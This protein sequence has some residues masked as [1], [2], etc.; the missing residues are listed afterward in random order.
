M[1]IYCQPRTE[2]GVIIATIIWAGETHM[3]VRYEFRDHDDQIERVSVAVRPIAL[4]L[5]SGEKQRWHLPI[6]TAHGK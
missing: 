2:G 6:R 4:G 3:T 5:W 1:P